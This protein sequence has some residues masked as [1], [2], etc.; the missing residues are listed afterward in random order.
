MRFLSPH[1]QDLAQ[2]RGFP[3]R[4]GVHSLPGDPDGAEAE[5]Q[6]VDIPVSIGLEALRVRV[7]GPA[8]ELDDQLLVAVERIKDAAA[9]RNVQLGLGEAVGADE[10][11]EPVL[12]LGP[13]G[14]EV[15]ADEGARAP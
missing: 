10:P 7:P 5:R 6:V 2:P 12:E 3:V 11:D 15:S 9:E 14:A 1:L 8:V 13:G 4:C